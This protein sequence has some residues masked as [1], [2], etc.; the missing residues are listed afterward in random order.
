MYYC[1]LQYLDLYKNMVVKFGYRVSI[2]IFWNKSR[3]KGATRI[4]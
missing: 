1:T 3:C 4:S 2:V